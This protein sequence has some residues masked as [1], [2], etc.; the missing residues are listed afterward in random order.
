MVSYKN[1][2]YGH[3]LVP[4]TISKLDELVIPFVE[5][6]TCID[7][8]R[9]IT[10]IHIVE[11]VSIPPIFEPTS[12]RY[13]NLNQALMEQA[14]SDNITRANNYLNKLVDSLTGGKSE[15]GWQVLCAYDIANA[16]SQFATKNRVD[17]IIMASRG[18]TGIQRWIWGSVTH[19][20]LKSIPVPVFVL[21][22]P[23]WLHKSD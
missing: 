8:A 16:I 14:I 20:V 19:K 13:V 23:R 21:R 5:A 15:I 17:F 3:V 11:K 9:R 2:V 18:R 22:V 7:M 1:M 6:I 4:L 12:G 10:F